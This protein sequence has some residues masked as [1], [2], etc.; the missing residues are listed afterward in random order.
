MKPYQICSGAAS[1][2]RV[3]LTSS[4]LGGFPGVFTKLILMAAF[5]FGFAASQAV[6]G[7]ADIEIGNKLADLL[8]AGRKVVSASQPLINNPDIGDKDFTGDKLVLEANAIYA[9][10]IGSPLLA[11]G[12]SDRDRQLLEAQMQAMR[13]IVDDHQADINRTGVGFK[14]FIPAVFARLV[15]EEFEAI[16]GAKARVRVTAPPD[17]VRNRKARPDSWERT[18][19][20][21]RL[22]ASDWPRGQPYTDVVEY[23]GRSAF[24]MLLPEYYGESCLACHGGPK[25]ETDLTGY[26]KEGGKAGDLGGVI[27]I[28]IFR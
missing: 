8:R 24:R 15:N 23:E 12:I 13:R 22:L 4:G 11:D 10:R 18:I 14:G 19:I 20:E 6:A 2:Q 17:L 26:P 9:K 3:V 25:G 21:T 16:A 7:E 1:D 28:V 27:S 5:C